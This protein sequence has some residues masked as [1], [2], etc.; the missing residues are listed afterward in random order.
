ML[1]AFQFEM[2]NGSTRSEVITDAIQI[3][4]IAD[5]VSTYPGNRNPV[6]AQPRFALSLELRSVVVHI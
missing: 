3:A 6:T 5:L 2:R 4:N 1:N